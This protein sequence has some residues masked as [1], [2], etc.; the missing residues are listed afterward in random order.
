VFASTF[1]SE[2]SFEVSSASL[3][4]SVVSRVAR[5]QKSNPTTTK[6]MNLGRIIG[7]DS[8]EELYGKWMFNSTAMQKRVGIT[9]RD[10][11]RRRRTAD[12][13]TPASV[14]TR[15]LQNRRV[16]DAE[17]QR[18]RLGDVDGCGARLR[19]L[20]AGAPSSQL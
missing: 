1:R 20:R 3:R 13:W 9:A 8:T 11:Q 16:R 18:I 7:S 12:G 15:T 17:T 14:W 19:F 10:T 2:K 4:N 6:R 5:L